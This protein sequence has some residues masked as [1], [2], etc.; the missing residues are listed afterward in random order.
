MASIH[1]LYLLKMIRKTCPEWL[2]N[3]KEIYVELCSI[4]NSEERKERMVREEEG[5]YMEMLESKL[6]AK[7]ML[8]YISH[9][10]EEIQTLIDIISIFTVDLI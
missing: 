10:P 3:Q 7:A 1:T 8:Q 6:V 4:W 2:G 5:T 9:H